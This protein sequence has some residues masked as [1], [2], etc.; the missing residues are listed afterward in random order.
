MSTETPEISESDYRKLVTKPLTRVSINNYTL[1]IMKL[2]HN[3][4]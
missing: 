2:I 3:K 1:S 4:F